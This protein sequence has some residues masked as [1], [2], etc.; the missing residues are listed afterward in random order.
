MAERQ[1]WGFGGSIDFV[2]VY[3]QDKIPLIKAVRNMTN[4]SL[5]DAKD[6]VEGILRS[7]EVI[8]TEEE[9]CN[10]G[11]PHSKDTRFRLD[12]SINTATGEFVAYYPSDN[13]ERAML[14]AN[15]TTFKE[16][17]A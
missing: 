1:V 2:G 11:V 16:Y 4:C 8:V 9:R 12:S 14:A 3:T 17:G 5:K 15:P 10:L 7:V 6:I 13:F